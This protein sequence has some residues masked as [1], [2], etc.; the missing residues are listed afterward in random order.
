MRD[1]RRQRGERLHLPLRR[2]L[3]DRSRSIAHEQR[4]VRR[5]RQ[6]R[7]HTE[8]GRIE[9]DAIVGR[10]P[11]DV[12]LEAARDVNQAVR[13]EGQRRGIRHFDR[14]R[15]PNAVEADAIER[16]RDFRIPAPALRDVQPAFSIEGGA[17]DLVDAGRERAR[18]LERHRIAQQLVD[19]DEHRSAFGVER[20][21]EA[22]ALLRGRDDVRAVRAD[23]H[24]GRPIGRHR[25]MHTRDGDAG[26]R[27]RPAW[28]NGGD[29]LSHDA[30]FELHA[31]SSSTFQ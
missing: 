15:L 3:Q 10:Q 21:D 25:Q 18:D 26:A 1:A 7:R 23:E 11:V 14:E 19:A 31:S 22:K 6:A 5:E 16:H 29:D 30:L 2:H 9:L 17:V 8:L 12:P 20:H 24:V 4:A 13:T 28:M 27:D